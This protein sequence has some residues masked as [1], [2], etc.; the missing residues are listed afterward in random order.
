M[1]EK[2]LLID[3]QSFCYRAFYAIPELSNSKG[4]P[5]NAI[6]GFI[7]M[8]RKLIATEKPDYVAVCFDRKEPTFRH[9]KYEDYKAHRKPMPEDLITQM[10]HIKEFVHA[11]HMRSFELAGFEADDLI[12]TLTRKA[13]SEG[14]DVLIATGDKDMF[15]LV[16]DQV[17]I[18]HTHK[19]RII[20][21]SEVGK[22]Y[23]GLKPNQV[24][25]ILALM[26]DASDGIPGVPGIGEKT[27]LQLVKEYGSVDGVYNHLDD[28]TASSRKK[29]LAENQQLARDSRYLAVIDCNVP[30]EVDLGELRLKEPDEARLAEFFKRFEFR[31]LLKELTPTGEAHSEKRSYHTVTTEKSLQALAKKLSDVSGFAIDTETTS[32]DPMQARL[33][34]ISVSFKAYEAHYIPVAMPEHQGKGLDL[35]TVQKHLQPVI[36]NSEV[37]KFGQNVKYD[38]LVLSRHGMTLQGKLFDTMVAS[39]LINPIKLNHNLDDIAFEYLGVRKITTEEILSPAD[40]KKQLTMDQ[41]ALEK[42]AE[43]ACE[44]ADCVFRLVESLQKLIHVHQLEKLFSEIEMP[45]VLVLAEME[46]NGVALDLKLLK[47]MSDDAEKDLAT[48][49]QKIYKEAGAE[50][51][52]NSTKQLADILFTKLKLPVIKRT[53]TGYSTDVGVLEKLAQSYELPKLL[54]NYRERSKLKS[55]YL[56]AFPELINPETGLI[57]TSFNQ[58]VTSTGRLSSSDPNLQN[59]PI[60]TEIGRE[61]RRAFVPRGKNRKIV[62]ADYSQI[63]LRVLAHMAEDPNLIQAFENDRDIHTFTATLLY[64]TDEKSVSRE[65]RNVAKTINFSIV[66]GVSAFGLASELKISISEAQAFIDSYFAR[67]SRVK[68]FLESMKKSA[69]ENGFLTTLF[70]RRSYFPDINS[71]NPNARQFAERAAINAPIQGTAADL[72]KLAMIRIQKDLSAK[73]MKSL[74][75]IQVHDELV[76]DVPD[77]ELKEAESL[78]RHGMEGAAK[79]K[80]PIK[81]DVFHGDSWFKP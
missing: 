42:V 55:T 38:Y 74:M 59:I 19:E 50:F 64:G 2:L 20:D 12:G 73:K 25:D 39:Y 32:P 47:R 22:I 45:L 36:E 4:E 43:Y 5:T 16:D 62:S 14:C 28:I 48:L 15:Q 51:N 53:K 13:K 44:D 63:E 40:G 72:I 65:M 77:E 46:R 27:A 52:I 35:A 7:T 26:G 31:S 8:L 29:L 71:H 81:V 11:S 34:G 18:Y 61:I 58:T 33:V 24:V 37:Q 49:T 9:Q 75:V 68:E 56:D 78:I 17:K 1:S 30:I 60:R 54:L 70:G 66:Y 79:L 76:F 57:H 3:G 21:E 67:Y 10:P 80:V 41:V 23:S 6:Y 69:R